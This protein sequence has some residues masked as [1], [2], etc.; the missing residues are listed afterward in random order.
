MAETPVA[1]TVVSRTVT[2]GVNLAASL[3]AADGTNGNSFVNDGTTLLRCK[4]AAGSPITLT[5]N[6]SIT[7]DGLAVADRT[8]S[9]PATTGDRLMG[10]FPVNYYG[11][12]VT[13]S[14]SSATSVTLGVY[15]P[16]S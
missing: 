3:T 8:Y 14:V 10:P 6:T 9:I 16:T 12:V 7:A 5:V 2:D 15:Q 1:A 13:I 11:S 4:N